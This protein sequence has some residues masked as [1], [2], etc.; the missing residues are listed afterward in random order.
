MQ[1]MTKRGVQWL[2]AAADNPEE[3][4]AVW[5]RDPRSPY[6]LPTGRFFDVVVIEQRVGLETFEQLDRR[7]LPMGPV[8]ADWGA[9][10]V[11]FFLPSKSRQR[12]DD[13][14][15]GET[16][17]PPEYRYLGP[18]SVVVV[19]GPMPLSGDRYAWLRAP[20]RRPEANPA[21][22]GALAAMFVA[23]ASVVLRADRYGEE[24]NEREV[25]GADAS[26]SGLGDAHAG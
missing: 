9:K 22:L 18:E 25:P 13:K 23:A 26:C 10:Q 6:T 14:V 21:R 3:C 24:Q 7:G 20:M 19:P 16:P 5:T 11:G 17:H 8:L 1:M 15:K 2:S 12:F 4:R